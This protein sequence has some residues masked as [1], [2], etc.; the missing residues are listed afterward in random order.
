MSFN[1]GA[2]NADS[3]RIADVNGDGI[4]D[5]VVA[6]ECGNSDCTSGAVSVLLGNG[7][8]T[9]QPAVNYSSAGQYASSVAVADVKSRR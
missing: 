7:N 9:F 4:P 1:S 5:L 6:N 2:E 3:V 8:G